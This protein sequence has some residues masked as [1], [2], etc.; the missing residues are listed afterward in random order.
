MSLEGRVE[1]FLLGRNGRMFLG[2]YGGFDPRRFLSE[3]PFT[4]HSLALWRSTLQTRASRLAKLGI[5]YVFLIAPDAH[6]VYPDDLPPNMP[7]PQRTA[8]QIFVD[9]MGEIDNLKIVH[10]LDVLREATGGIDVY[11]KNDS[12]WS[13]YGAFLAYQELINALPSDLPLRKLTACDVSFQMKDTFGLF[14]AKL[15][16]PVPSIANACAVAEEVHEGYRRNGIFRTRCDAA[17]ATAVFFRDSF[18]TDMA[19]F[20][21]ET[22]YRAWMVG[23]TARLFYD[24]VREVKPDVV[25]T[26]TAERRLAIGYESDHS[27]L[28]H[29]ELFEIRLKSQAG[30]A[31]AFLL[32]A[33]DGSRLEEALERAKTVMASPD[34]LPVHKLHVARA[35]HAANRLEEAAELLD[36]VVNKVPELSSGWRLLALIAL[37]QRAG[38]RWRAFANQMIAGSPDNALYLQEY[39]FGLSA[40]G[41]RKEAVAILEK[42]VLKFPD[43][44]AMRVLLAN[45]L[46]AL[47]DASGALAAI[48][49]ALPFYDENSSPH[50]LATQLGAAVTEAHS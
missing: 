7:R 29:R 42:A 50:N 20:A 49:P 4:P 32:D 37:R 26:V 1:E 41:R 16:T 8:G 30:K 9:A 21:R 23:A 18:F 24:L 5:P 34:V 3:Q 15:P 47:G 36:D 43:H 40:F 12:H 48:K 35:L 6:S 14:D 31:C 27:A 25:V 38:G 46:K 22:F 45:E 39:L 44:P 11:R 10:T 17:Q 19:P 13:A 28:G 2:H 33:L